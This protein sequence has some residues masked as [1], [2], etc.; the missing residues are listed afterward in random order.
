MTN[1]KPVSPAQKIFALLIAVVFIAVAGEI[2]LRL[3]APFPDYTLYSI[4][5]FPDQY[6]PLLGY[7]GVPGLD[8]WFILP[9][10]KHRIV[11]NSRGFRDRER[12]YDKGGQKRIVV[13]GDSTAWGWGVE[14]WERFSDIIEKRL[15]GWEVINLAQAGY[16]TDQELIVLETEGLKYHPD[17]VMLLFDRNDVVEGNN[18]KIIDGMQPKPYF[19]EEG[20]RLVV[21]NSPVP[22]EGAYWMQKRM[23]AGSYGV[24][25]DGKPPRSW[26][27]RRDR[28]FTGSHLYNWIV[29]RLAHPIW[30]KSEQAG[31]QGDL[32]ELEKNM[33]LTKRLLGEI[34]GLC[35]QN[36]AR[37]VVADIHSVYSPLL[38]SFCQGAGIGYVDLGPPLHG[39]IRPIEHRRVGHWNAYGHKIVADAMMDYLTKNGYVR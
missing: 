8:T 35:A 17:V 7:A 5:C 31:A 36:G 21:K 20:G 4:R 29:F 34:N 10:F 14:T 23:L 15:K 9:D 26:R 3:F 12:A 30:T 11:N 33:Y 25:D 38:K 19:V 39:R 2:T 6:H 1:H 37:F 32:R 24:T 18:A 16:S 13:L 27:C 22:F 28:I